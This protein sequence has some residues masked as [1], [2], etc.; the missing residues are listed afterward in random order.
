M[1]LRLL[2]SDEFMHENSGESNFN[3]SMYFNFFDAGQGLGGFARIGNR[4]NEGHAETTVCLFEPAGSV[5]FGFERAAIPD[6]RAFDAGGMRFE[7]HE[8]FERL[9]VAYR[10]KACRLG[11]PLA[12]ADPR[13]AFRENPFVPIDLDLEVRGVGPMFGGE[14]TGHRDGEME[15]ARGH[16]EQHHRARGHVEIDGRRHAFDGLGLRDHSWGPRSWQAPAWYRWL[17]AN[18]G[19]DFGFMGSHIMRRDGVETRGG[20]VH[21]GRQLVPVRDIRIETEFG[22]RER[23]H[24]RLRARLD[25]A[26]GSS[27]EVEGRVLSMIPLRNRRDGRVTRIGEGMTEWRCAGRTGYGLSE[28]LDQVEP[29]AG[30][31]SPEATRE[32]SP[33]GGAQR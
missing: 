11:D 26:D 15:F 9:R 33:E 17:T 32:P 19:D 5:V 18:F 8:P 14:P 30:S 6:N 4:P 22:G 21:R 27:L 13:R 7:V 31:H 10:G 23:L 1:P 20:F 2:P 12:M 24:Q 28:Y 3:E 25:C 29:G 16:Y